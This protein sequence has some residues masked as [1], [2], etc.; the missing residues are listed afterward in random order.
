VRI[1]TPEGVVAGASSAGVPAVLIGHNDRIAWGFTTTGSDTQDLVA[2]RLVDGDPTR[3]ATPDGPRAFQTREEVIAVRG[4][5]PVRMA[6]REG[7]FGPV[8]SDLP[9]AAAGTKPGTVLTL[10]WPALADDDTSADALVA[11]NHAQD[12]DDFT[13]ALERWVAPQQNVFY[14]DT[15]GH[16]G[17]Y[18]PGRTPVRTDG[19]GSVPLAGEGLRQ[20]WSGFIPFA[21]LPHALDPAGGLLVNANNRIVGPDYPYLLSTDW[22]APYRAERIQSV[23]GNRQG[24]TA[25]D[26]V[27]LQHDDLSEVARD[28]LPLMLQAAPLDGIEARARDLLAAWDYRMDRDRPEPLL[29]QAWLFHLQDRL[30]APLGPAAADLP[31]WNPTAV[32]AILTGHRDWCARTG[33]DCPGLLKQGLSLALAELAPPGSGA[34]KDLSQLRWGDHHRVHLANPIFGRIPW[35]AW[36][37]TTV[38]PTDGGNYTVN[39]ATPSASWDSRYQDVHGAGLRAVFDLADLDASRFVIAGGQ[40]GHPLSPHWADLAEAWRDGHTVRLVAPAED[41]AER[42]VLRPL[43]REPEHAG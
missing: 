21:D 2:E 4:G 12:W 14:A 25:Q 41:E 6:V 18:P 37:T 35:L 40:S 32:K 19:D 28:L 10:A 5:D 23:L 38:L 43:R 16:I 34:A 27:D 9:S 11:V 29:F 31:R 1:E 42:L 30:M 15:A 13:A 26:M 17:F 39:R 7:R 22:E 24:L 8:V 33:Q 20:V 36:A 3:Y